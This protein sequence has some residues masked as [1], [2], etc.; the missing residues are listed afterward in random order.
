[1]KAVKNNRPKQARKP[2]SKKGKQAFAISASVVAVALALTLSLTFGLKKPNTPVE[3]EVPVVVPPVQ[4]G[5]EF[6]L[7]LNDCTVTKSAALTRL[8]YNDTLNQ[9]TAHR[10]VDFKAD[11]G[12]SVMTIAAGTVLDV[13]NTILEGT[14]VTVQHS[15]GYVSIYKGLGSASVAKGDEID[16]GAN[17]GVVGVMSCESNQGAHLHLEL[18]KDGKY[19][20]ATDY[21]DAEINK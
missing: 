21:I 19:V 20:S 17:I 4:T 1:M 8:V 14:V 15:N 2:M 6:T 12:E 16:M 10:G 18:K 13:E 7:P 3:N 11:A 9:W 5:V